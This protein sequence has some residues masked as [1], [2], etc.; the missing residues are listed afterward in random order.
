MIISHVLGYLRQL[1][2]LFR[3]RPHS[4]LNK[5]KRFTTWPT[6]LEDS[7]ERGEDGGITVEA[8]QGKQGS[9]CW[10]WRLK[11]GHSAHDGWD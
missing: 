4:R 5:E 9:D 8:S 6:H 3:E 7:D 1:W 2:A 10:A 11:N